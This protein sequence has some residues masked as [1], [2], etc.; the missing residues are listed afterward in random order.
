MISYLEFAGLLNA[1]QLFSCTVGV[2]QCNCCCSPATPAHPHTR[3]PDARAPTHPHACDEV[4]MTTVSCV[5]SRGQWLGRACVQRRAAAWRS[6]RTQPPG[7]AARPQ[8]TD[9]A[10]LAFLHGSFHLVGLEA[11]VRVVTV[12][13]PLVRS[14]HRFFGCG[15]LPLLVACPCHGARVCGSIAALGRDMLRGTAFTQC[16]HMAAS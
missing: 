4:T 2:A 1:M 13:V 7:E 6:M 9:R 12:V 14:G 15:H 5:P 16:R 10:A 3:T 8:C 11:S